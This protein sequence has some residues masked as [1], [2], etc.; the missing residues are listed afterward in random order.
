MIG[1]YKFTN[2]I[3]NKIY[4]GLSNNI[5]RRY[6]EHL[7][8]SQSNK[9]KMY[10]HAALRKYGIKNFS[11]EVLETFEQEDRELLAERERYW[12]AYY[13]SYAE[14]YNETP[15]GDN[16]DGR[17][18]LTK[19]DVIAIRKRYN[20]LER[21]CIVYE[22]YKD[23]INRTGFNKIWKGETWKA[24]MPEV[25]TPEHKQYHKMHTANVGARNGRARLTEQDV[26][27]IRTRKAHGETA[28]SVYQDYQDK[29]T[30]G[31]F[32]NVFCGYNWKHIHID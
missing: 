30:Y 28:S 16:Q 23:R 8:L 4:I 29:L 9:D 21:C 14:G 11:F 19:E 3:N 26:I 10:F 12:I 13:N 6:K 2:L 22:D 1:I 32:H 20:N 25:Y 5:E 17:T 15:G 7:Y 24:I 31:S 18:K 27:D